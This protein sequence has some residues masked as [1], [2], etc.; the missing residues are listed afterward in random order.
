MNQNLDQLAREARRLSSKQEGDR[1]FADLA[2]AA[3]PVAFR[4][5]NRIL[6]DESLA[7]DAMQETLIKLTK[8]LALYDP[9]RP[10]VP[11]LVRMATRTALDLHRRE[12]LV[13]QLPLSAANELE[14]GET[15]RPDAMVDAQCA[16][17]LLDRLAGELSHRQ[18]TVFVLRDLEG[19]STREIADQ[20][21]MTTSTVRV[22]L[23]RARQHVRTRWLALNDPERKSDEM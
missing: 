5:A 17:D 4:L 1:A 6:G 2:R 13:I 7:A 8:K 11:W 10:F 21:S 18:R 22:H 15:S 19:F 14:A 12:N 23:A 16:Q 3:G 9:A 20:L